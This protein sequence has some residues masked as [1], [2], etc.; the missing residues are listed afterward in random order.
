MK[1]PSITK[2]WLM[3]L[4]SVSVGLL[5]A[6]GL[7]KM[8][9]LKLGAASASQGGVAY[10]VATTDI[11]AGERLSA[12]TVS[13]REIPKEWVQSGG[14][15]AE[16]Y[17]SIDGM[18]T[19]TALKRGDVVQLAMLSNP[20]AEISGKIPLGHRAITI[21]VDDQ[22]SI[23]SM[24][25]PGDLIDLLVT[26]ERSGK[27]ATLPL[28]EGVM[29]LATGNQ[30][31]S[32]ATT[33]TATDVGYNTITLD[34]RQED[35]KNIILASTLGKITAVLRNKRDQALGQSHSILSYL[36]TEAPP[37]PPVQAR[38]SPPPQRNRPV[39]EPAIDSGPS[40]VYGNK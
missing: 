38:L 29:I 22:S 36:P 37:L 21:P 28:M 25:K 18:V 35:A 4:L 33:A 13:S 1:I 11:A 2:N 27:A 10:V 24:L 5:G 32:H 39:A 15:P 26:L 9:D 20:E 12:D 3:L 31:D 19:T 17:A 40:I 34:V 6:V 14:V 7:K 16:Q 8:V 23:S 30:L